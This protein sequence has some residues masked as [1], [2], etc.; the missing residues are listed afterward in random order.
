MRTQS[1]NPSTWFVCRHAGSIN[2]A[3]RQ[4]LHIDHYV[5]HLDVLHS[6][7]PGDMVIGTLPVQLIH[8][9]N[10]RGVRYKHLELNLSAQ[11]RGQE[12]SAHDIKRS[13]PQL[14]EF[15]VMKVEGCTSDTV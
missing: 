11:Q 9:L 6:P 10:Q 1:R 14:T 8:T 15:L 13:D 2:W 4:K 5:E 3:K 12:L 7:A